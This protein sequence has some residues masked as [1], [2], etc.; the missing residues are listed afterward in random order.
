MRSSINEPIIIQAAEY[1]EYGQVQ[2]LFD[3]GRIVATLIN[4]LAHNPRLQPTWPSGCR[5]RQRVLG[6]ARRLEEVSRF[7][8][9]RPGR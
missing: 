7:L 2:A 1:G 6:L 3:H 5:Y 9:N 4:L 8:V